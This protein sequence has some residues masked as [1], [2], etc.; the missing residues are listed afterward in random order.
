MED[1]F[2]QLEERVS[3]LEQEQKNLSDF[4]A[5]PYEVIQAVQRYSPRLLYGSATIDFGSIGAGGS[6]DG[7]V[8]VAGA[9]I[10]DIVTLG[11]PIAQMGA[12]RIF[13]G[14][15][16]SQDNVTIRFENQ[17]AGVVDLGSAVYNVVVIK[18]T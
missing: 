1:K 4:G 17:T 14:Y 2:K 15:V 7:T 16:T 13:T 10:G 12:S 9:S 8:Y 3:N 5:I 18:N 11:L 6:T